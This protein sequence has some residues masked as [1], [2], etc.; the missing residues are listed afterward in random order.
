[1][2][3]TMYT[4]SQCIFVGV[5]ALACFSALARDHLVTQKHE[6]WE[7]SSKILNGTFRFVRKYMWFSPLVRC[8]PNQIGTSAL[9]VQQ[10]PVVH[11]SVTLAIF[12]LNP[13]PQYENSHS[14]SPVKQKETTRLK[15][16]HTTWATH[17]LQCNLIQVSNEAER[18]TDWHCACLGQLEIYWG[19]NFEHAEEGRVCVG[20][21]SFVWSFEFEG[22]QSCEFPRV[23]TWNFWAAAW[24][25]D[26]FVWG[27][28][29]RT[30][31]TNLWLSTTM[32]RMV[33]NTSHL[34]LYYICIC[35]CIRI[36]ICIW[37]L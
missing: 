5:S 27:A 14:G 37:L 2:V 11:C 23:L 19:E 20:F 28:S 36:C 7:N 32:R 9:W 18:Q 17:A 21:W 13:M 6:Q 30:P 15:A 26:G 24:L 33:T 8:Y 4:Y 16:S 12:S 29:T 31:A 25:R 35:V 34:C 1:M 3:I 10:S 22:M